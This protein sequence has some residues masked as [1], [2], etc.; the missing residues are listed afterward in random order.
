MGGG[1]QVDPEGAWIG[2]QSVGFRLLE[3]GL[4]FGGP[5]LTATD[6]ACA[7]GRIDLGERSRVS[8]LSPRFV[9]ATLD[10]MG[11][12]IA[13][14]VDRMKTESGDVKLLAVGG[15]SFLVPDRVSRT[16]RALRRSRP[17]RPRPSNAPWRRGRTRGA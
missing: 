9:E 13:D 16:C 11:E 5:T 6:I 12:M 10:R 17:R 15:G 3:Q 7:A 8:H 1:T 14:G 2:P 4:V